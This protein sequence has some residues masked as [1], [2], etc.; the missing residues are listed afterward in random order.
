MMEEQVAPFSFYETKAL[1]RQHFLD[2]TFWHFLPPKKLLAAGNYFCWPLNYRSRMPLRTRPALQE[3]HNYADCGV[4]GRIWV[5]LE[6]LLLS[7]RCSPRNDVAG[8]L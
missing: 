4:T 7:H 1:V 6:S 2:F 5:G 3:G 8:E